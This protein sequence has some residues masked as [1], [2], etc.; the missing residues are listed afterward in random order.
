MTTNVG[1]DVGK[2]FKCKLAQPLWKLVWW[3]IRKLR[4]DLPQDPSV[5]FLGRYPKTLHPTTEIIYSPMY[6]TAVVLAALN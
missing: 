3:F 6:V 4:I 2:G 5:S 1:V